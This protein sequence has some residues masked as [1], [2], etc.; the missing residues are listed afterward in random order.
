[1]ARLLSDFEPFRPVQHGPIGASARAEERR[2]E[3]AGAPESRASKR[4]NLEFVEGDLP[5]ILVEPTVPD[6]ETVPVEPIPLPPVAPPD[7][8][9][10]FENDLNGGGGTMNFDEEED[11]FG[12]AMNDT[13]PV[14]SENTFDP[15]LREGADFKSS[16]FIDS[17]DRQ[18]DFQGNIFENTQGQL[19]G[20]T[21]FR[22]PEVFEGG[23]PGQGEG[24]PGDLEFGADPRMFSFGESQNGGVTPAA[25][26][27]GAALGG[28]ALLLFL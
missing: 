9:D 24:R 18:R 13:A 27:T 17:I 2:S 21:E 14:P 16:F 7:H 20:D 11:F 25:I 3:R 23:K 22:S 26:A 10:S 28:L 5:P 15:T 6:E 8:G 19:T 12:G 4:Q 1:M